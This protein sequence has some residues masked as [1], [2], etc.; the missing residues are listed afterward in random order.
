MVFSSEIDD[1]YMRQS[2][3]RYHILSSSISKKSVKGSFASK[4]RYISNMPKT[5]K[6]RAKTEKS[7][8]KRISDINFSMKLNAFKDTFCSC[9]LDTIECTENNMIGKEMDEERMK[10]CG[11]F[12]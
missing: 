2:T 4:S 5:N 11:G 9:E 7:Y 8:T 1:N 3:R 6:I 10:S 12:R